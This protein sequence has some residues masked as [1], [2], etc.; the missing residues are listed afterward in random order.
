MK[1]FHMLFIPILILLI[2]VNAYF[3]AAEIA[4]VSVRKFRVQEEAD[5]GNKQ[6]RQIL[7][8]L[9]DPDEYLSAIQVGITLVGMIE[10]LYG[11]E[12]LERYLEPVFARWGM[13]SW[14][15][16]LLSIVVGIGFITY[17][18]IVIG[19]LLPKSI[20]LQ[21]PQRTAFRIAPSF[22]LFTILAWPFV[23]LLTLGTHFMVRILGIRGSENKMLTDGDLRGI[24]GL[25]Y[26]QG[27]LEKDELVLHENIFSFYEINVE[28]IMTTR[29]KV[30]VIGEAMDGGKVEET[31]RKSTHNY[32][33]VVRPDNTI[34]G[35]L[36]AREFFMHREK[37]LKE[38]IQP[39]CTL[40]GSQEASELLKKFKERG[41]NFGIV[42]DDGG[43]LAGVVTMHDIAEVLVGKIP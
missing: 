3:S 6:A 2:L 1:N 35:A 29:E 17:I 5:K 20:A 26:R 16:H 23:K 43:R 30:V 8:F 40:M 11:G 27:V 32:F 42:V 31:L 24:L 41:Q 7:D 36:C 14:L 39:A 25:A 38:H 15:A 18:T 28:K 21:Q 37:P 22:R 33:P 34:S 4:I 13:A 19:E 9:K 10:G 12:V